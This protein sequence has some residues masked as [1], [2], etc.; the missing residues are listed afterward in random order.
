ML[1]LNYSQKSASV[2]MCQY[3]DG[4]RN[5]AATFKFV[6]DNVAK[7]KGVRNITSQHQGHL[8]QMYSLLA[9]KNRVNPPPPTPLSE[10]FQRSLIGISAES[11]LPTE[12]DITRIMLNFTTLVCRFMC[13][14]IKGLHKFAKLVPNH[15]YHSHSKDMAEKSEVAVLDVLHKNEA[16]HVDMLDI[17]KEQQSYLGSNFSDKVL[18]GGDQL[19]CERQRCAQLHVMDSD[20]VVD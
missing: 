13:V 16:S 3:R 14:Y 4:F 18:S 6:G 19:T 8:C 15:I 10:S 20:N 12:A 2:M 17:M 9:V 5:H 1:Y 11:L 7:L